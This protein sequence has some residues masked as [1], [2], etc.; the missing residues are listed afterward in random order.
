MAGPKNGFE[1]DLN[2]AHAF[3]KLLDPEAG[4]F[5]FQTFDDTPTKSRSLAKVW[6][7]SLEDLAEPLATLQQ[8][9]AGVFVT[10]NETTLSGRRTAQSIVAVRAVF[11]DLDGAPLEP[12]HGLRAQAALHRREQPRASSTPIGACTTCRSSSSRASESA[13]REVQRRQVGRRPAAGHA[14]A[15]LLAPEGR[16]VH[17]PRFYGRRRLTSRTPPSSCSPSSRRSP[18]P[19]APPATATTKSWPSWCGRS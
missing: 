8:A 19:A 15:R 3:L 12:V 10:I 7:G 16:A 4:A 2:Q 17:D 14:P 5:T 6:H 13:R 1:P 11:V 9:G 18:R